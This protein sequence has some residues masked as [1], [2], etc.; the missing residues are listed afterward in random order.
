M[1][2]ENLTI[3]DLFDEIEKRV[4]RI[5]RE[6]ITSVILEGKPLNNDLIITP[7]EKNE[8]TTSKAAIPKLLTSKEVAEILK[9][10]VQ[11]VWELA[12]ESKSNGFPV[13]VLGERQY[14]FSQDAIISWIQRGNQ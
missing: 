5:I 11:R 4:R 9:V 14:R 7:N 1:S 12:R 10:S 3:L 13:I 6:E 8:K 2:L